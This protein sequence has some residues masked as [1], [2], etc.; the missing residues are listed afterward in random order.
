MHASSCGTSQAGS[1]SS[2]LGSSDREPDEHKHKGWLLM[3]EHISYEDCTAKTKF[4][5][6]IIL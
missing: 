6:I 5:V 2:L 3:M 4:K 1:F